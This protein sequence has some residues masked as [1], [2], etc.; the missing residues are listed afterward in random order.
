[1]DLN[2][3]QK[4][5]FVL[6]IIL[7][8]VGI[9]SY[10]VGALSAKPA[11]VPMWLMLKAVAGNVLFHHQTHADDNGYGIACLDC[12]H[13]PQEEDADAQAC[14]ACHSPAGDLESVQDTCLECHSAED[15]EDIEPVKRGAAFHQQCIGCHEE[16]GIGPGEKSCNACHAL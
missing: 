6:A 3:D 8:I 15:Y 11:E 12:H 5:A 10:A 1:M 4:F 13:H 2:Q 14:G 9:F 16:L 7:L